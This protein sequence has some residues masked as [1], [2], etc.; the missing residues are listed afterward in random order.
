MKKGDVLVLLRTAPLVAIVKVTTCSERAG[1]IARTKRSVGE[2]EKLLRLTF[3]LQ[4]H[5]LVFL[6]ACNPGD[7]LYEIED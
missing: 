5:V 3:H 1:H 4:P 2:V 6:V 7:P